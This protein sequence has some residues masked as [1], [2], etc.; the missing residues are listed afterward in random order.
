MPPRL[1]AFLDRPGGCR[2][3]NQCRFSHASPSSPTP[4]S[5]PS[6][7][8]PSQGTPLLFP[9]TPHPRIPPGVC[10]FYWTTGQCRLEFACRFS[11]TGASPVQNAAPQPITRPTQSFAIDSIAPFLTEAGLARVTGT[12]TDVFFPADSSKDLSPT[13]AHNALKRFLLD[14]YRFQATFDVYAFLKPLSSAH[15]ANTSWVSS[16]L[17]SEWALSANTTF[18]LFLVNRR[19]S[20]KQNPN[21]LFDK[22]FMFSGCSFYCLAVAHR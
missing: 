16:I 22:I 8:A 13:E 11:H 1:C 17:V 9:P 12:S 20:S 3:G 15:A 21:F 18:V 4:S 7:P 14:H 2:R 5:R 19:R 10:R 6:S